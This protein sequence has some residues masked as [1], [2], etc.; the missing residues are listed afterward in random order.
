MN[1]ALDKIQGR[2]TATT[3]K[4]TSVVEDF[5]LPEQPMLDEMTRVALSA[6][7]RNKQGFV[8]MIESAS[9]LSDEKLQAAYA[10]NA[11]RHENW[12][13]NPKP[14][15]DSQQ[16]FAKK[17]PLN[18]Y[19]T[20]AM[21]RDSDDGELLHGNIHGDSAAH[22]G[23]DVPLS[24]YGPGAYDFTGTLDNTDIFFKIAKLMIKGASKSPR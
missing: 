13:T 8:L 10:A 3:G 18:Q 19:P 4:Q 9:K 24:A 23:S 7:Q 15:Q 5:G 17:E 2:R 22:T 6:L 16:P 21:E 1:V 20:N 14:L 12:R 11:D